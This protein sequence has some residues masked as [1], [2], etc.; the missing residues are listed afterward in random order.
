MMQ[1]SSLKPSTTLFPFDPVFPQNELGAFL[2]ACGKNELE[3][4][5][6][7]VKSNPEVL[8]SFTYRGVNGFFLAFVSGYFRI[9][10]LLFELGF[11]QNK[12]GPNEYSTFALCFLSLFAPQIQAKKDSFA[13]RFSLIELLLSKG[14]DTNFELD[15]KN[16]L[17][18]LIDLYEKDLISIET[19]K[20]IIDGNRLNV[21]AS[22]TI[23][24][25]LA[26]AFFFND[27]KKRN[28]LAT[29]LIQRNAEAIH[30]EWKKASELFF[31]FNKETLETHLEFLS[32]RLVDIYDSHR[33][34]K[35]YKRERT[36]SKDVTTFIK[37]FLVRSTF[38]LE[39]VRKI[40]DEKLS[41]ITLETLSKYDA[42][43]SFQKEIMEKELKNLSSRKRIKPLK[44]KQA[45]V[46]KTRLIFQESFTYPIRFE[47]I[48]T[49]VEIDPTVLNDINVTPFLNATLA[50]RPEI[51]KF[52]MDKGTFKKNQFYSLLKDCFIQLSANICKYQ[53]RINSILA[54]I[55][56]YIRDVSINVYNKQGLSFINFL[57]FL[58]KSNP[59]VFDYLQ[60]WSDLNWDLLNENNSHKNAFCYALE[61]LNEESFEIYFRCFPKILFPIPKLNIFRNEDLKEKAA[62]CL[63]EIFNRVN[64]VLACQTFKESYLLLKEANSYFKEIQDLKDKAK[65]ATR[66]E[67][68]LLDRLISSNLL[69]VKEKKTLKE[70]EAL[71]LLFENLDYFNIF[72]KL[73]ETFEVSISEF[74]ESNLSINLSASANKEL[75]SLE[76]NELLKKYYQ[77]ASSY[78]NQKNKAP[79][80]QTE[81]FYFGSYE[82]PTP[83]VKVAKG[84]KPT[85]KE[86]KTEEIARKLQNKN[87]EKQRASLIE[88]AKPKEKPGPLSPIVSKNSKRKEERRLNRVSKK[89]ITI[90]ASLSSDIQE[91]FP[92]HDFPLDQLTPLPKKTKESHPPLSIRS[93]QK[94][95][96]EKVHFTP[97][98]INRLQIAINACD[99]ISKILEE[100]KYDKFFL[101]AKSLRSE[102]YI[103][104]LSYQILRF[105]EALAPTSLEQKDEKDVVFF[106]EIHHFFLD[107]DEIRA[108]RRACRTSFSLLDPSLL[109]DLSKTL[110]DVGLS[111]TLKEFTN[112]GEAPEN[113]T[114]PSLHLI[115][116][117]QIPN[118]KMKL[119][120]MA[121]L[122]AKILLLE[123]TYNEIEFIERCIKAANDKE[124]FNSY[125]DAIKKALSDLSIFASLLSKEKPPLKLLK[126]KSLKWLIFL[127]NKIAHHLKKGTEIG[128]PIDEVNISKIWNFFDPK[129]NH[130]LKLKE[131]IDQEKN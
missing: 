104:S 28:E 29:L 130:V 93:K 60:N 8:H 1:S 70:T 117:M 110:V 46:K 128:K 80:S 27:P 50:G 55:D 125:L 37:R 6:K 91:K 119:K 12:R 78:Q 9:I 118:F 120:E 127:G 36:L 71:S 48:R 124:T 87:L 106:K 3:T 101:L 108:V 92:I 33:L 113:F 51:I 129:N 68:S 49:V 99:R 83:K 47:R 53:L 52:L 90:S 7:L 26:Q 98:Q 10:N 81:P 79:K 4:V 25:P 66:E 126:L 54:C 64:K 63:K 67:A 24:L 88:S 31:N 97:Q 112:K 69:G 82:P 131:A 105:C 73:L 15:G 74:N 85:T 61:T 45:L 41:E 18:S 76:I 35:N 94:S 19:L 65:L 95:A 11:D 72:K 23:K 86:L 21:N 2:E 103:K 58:S 5:R 14:A 44:T 114:K 122:E 121:P 123:G 111:S 42:V 16:F 56:L 77:R 107:K 40:L 34:I 75:P 43:Y 20:Q 100:I 57:I 39:I 38:P 13:F 96:V 62:C 17:D 59:V 102:I 109:F 32:H 115:L 89:E 116:K 30:L 22:S 84:F